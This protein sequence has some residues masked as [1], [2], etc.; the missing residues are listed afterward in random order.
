[1][2]AFCCSMRFP[3]C[4]TIITRPLRTSGKPFK[5]TLWCNIISNGLLCFNTKGPKGLDQSQKPFSGVSI[6]KISVTLIGFLGWS[7]CLQLEWLNIQNKTNL[8]FRVPLRYLPPQVLAPPSSIL[9][10]SANG[11]CGGAGAN[12]AEAAEREDSAGGQTLPL[13]HSFLSQLLFYI[14]SLTI[15]PDYSWERMG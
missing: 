7:T 14:L 5:G 3:C 10:V 4:R 6:K 11:G 8:L 15:H 13:Q 12:A 9:R 2:E 1:M